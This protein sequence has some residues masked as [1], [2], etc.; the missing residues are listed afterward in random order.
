V[1]ELRVPSD[2]SQVLGFWEAE[3]ERI[4]KLCEEV[5]SEPAVDKDHL[6][7]HRED[8]QIGAFYVDCSNA[9][10][11]VVHGVVPSKLLLQKSLATLEELWERL[12]KAKTK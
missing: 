6:P 4:I 7:F 3:V 2:R 12:G 1:F 5:L 9:Y 11:T 10:S 8:C